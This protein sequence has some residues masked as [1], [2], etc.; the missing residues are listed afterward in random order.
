MGGKQWQTT[1]KKLA[2]DAAYHSH[3]GGLT[4][5]WFLPKLAQGLNTNNK[6]ISFHGL[7]LRAFPFSY[8]FYYIPKP[9]TFRPPVNYYCYIFY[10]S[11]RRNGLLIQDA[12]K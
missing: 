8:W 6:I 10:T 2:Q 11:S 7:R 9:D 4:G 5:H 3:T 12:D 1:P